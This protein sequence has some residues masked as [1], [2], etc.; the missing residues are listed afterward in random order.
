MVKARAISS[1]SSSVTGSFPMLL[2]S[3]PLRTIVKNL[4]PMIAPLYS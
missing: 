4:K 2:L 1:R 3:G